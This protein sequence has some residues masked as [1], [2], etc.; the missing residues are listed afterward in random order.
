MKVTIIVGGRFHAFD[1]AMQLKKH[2]MLYQLVTTYPKKKARKFN[3]EKKEIVSLWFIEYFKRGIYKIFGFFPLNQFLNNLFDHL[4]S[5]IVKK[6]ADVYIIWAGMA[7]HSIK[8]IK[9]VNPNAKI[10]IERGSTHIIEQNELLK[11]ISGK[12]IVDKRTIEKET[13]EY[14]LADFISI[15][16]SFSKKG[17]LKFNIKEDKLFVNYYGVELKVFYPKEKIT[18]NNTFTIGYAGTL[19]AQKNILGI[20]NSTKKLIKKGYNIQLKLVGNIDNKTFDKYLLQE[21][22]ITYKAAI[23]QAE[24]IDFYN[25]IDTFILN[26]VQDGFGMV[27]LQALSCGIP[28][29]ATENTGGIDIIKDFYNGFIVPSFDDEKLQ[30]KIEFICN[31]SAE[32]RKKLSKNALNS[33]KLGFTWDDYGN[34]YVEFLKNMLK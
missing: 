3:I 11:K 31:L 6:D 20:I 18:N 8:R 7:L 10:I 23:P 32:K 33:V 17:F 25:E 22:F 1:L 4:V 19:S 29:I 15:P 27:I 34:R 24:L 12:N 5:S 26:S 30:E 14:V 2:N 16:G 13:Q 9:K 21:E 28:V